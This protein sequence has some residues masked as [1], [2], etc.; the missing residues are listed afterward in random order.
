M[1]SQSTYLPFSQLSYNPEY[2]SISQY[3]P[4]LLSLELVKWATDILFLGKQFMENAKSKFPK[5]Y[6]DKM[7]FYCMYKS[8]GGEVMHEVLDPL[9]GQSWPEYYKLPKPKPRQQENYDMVLKFMVEDFQP[10]LTKE[11]WP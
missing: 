8:P 10:M 2:R 7:R 3:V 5:E 4:K 1:A 6:Y 11:L 9:D